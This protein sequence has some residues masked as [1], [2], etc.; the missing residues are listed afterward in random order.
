MSEHESTAFGLLHREIQ[1]WVWQQA[2]QSLRGIQEAAIPVVLEGS[3]DVLLSAATS[4]GKTE[5]AFLPLLS[6]VLNHDRPG[7]RILYLSPLKALINDQFRRL[8]T[9]CEN[10]QITV[11]RWHGDVAENRKRQALLNPSG[12]L[13]MTP[14]SLE[15]L[16]M[17][18]GGNLAAAFGNLEGVVVDEAHAYIGSERG[19]QVQ[20][21]LCRLENVAGRRIPRV[22]LSA[23]IGDLRLAAEFLRP[24]GGAEVRIV[25]VDGGADLLLQLRGYCAGPAA[26]GTE[27]E[28]T[29]SDGELS[30]S[31]DLF[32][33][34][35][36]GKN[37]VFA[38]SRKRVE[39]HAD[40]L[41]QMAAGDPGAPRF[42]VH[43]GS[44]SRQLREEAETSL[45]EG[46]HP[47]TV[48]ATTTL[49][50]G[51]DIGDIESIA[52]V[53]CPPSV[54]S[55]RQRV[56]RS[57]RRTGVATLRSFI[58]EDKIAPDSALLDK[59]RTELFQTTAMLDLM[60][61]RWTEPPEA[62]AYHL[63]TLVQQTLALIA[64]HGGA[65]ADSLFDQLCRRGPFQRTK[66]RDYVE[67][68][69][70]L[71]Q[72]SVIAQA[73][74]GLLL[75]GTQG[76]KFLAHYSFYAAFASSEEM[77]VETNGTQIGTISV[78]QVL[79]PDS[80]L[81][82]GGRRWQ[83]DSIDG[84][85]KVVFVRP[86]QGGRVPKFDP[87]GLPL[88]HANVRARMKRL[89]TEESPP[90]Y[91]D[92]TAQRLFAEGQT[93][94]RELGLEQRNVVERGQ[95][96]LLFHWHGD[97]V[98]NTIALLLRLNGVKAQTLGMAIEA[99]A[100]SETVLAAL[101]AHVDAPELTPAELLADERFI[102]REKWDPLV[103]RSL[104]ERDYALRMTDQA[105]ARALIGAILS[106]RAVRP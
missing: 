90:E 86:A 40:R 75:P 101:Q 30:A 4:S 19:A 21:L 95:S 47:V 74:D 10:L 100:A 78:S 35:R 91:L 77:R 26:G 48:V 99:S 69:R 89:Y 61:E 106:E 56:G 59:L 27:E 53:G 29:V 64:Q 94:F 11:H 98:A 28:E 81:I 79:G 32:R 71:G 23:T 80:L 7:F 63:S 34:L 57:G 58:I 8:D 15:A 49:E 45:R 72:S 83:V 105:A 102:D 51:I 87:N 5:A 20:S 67:L 97:R 3:A 55:L 60:L 12:V 31:R 73:G 70:H 13:L 52:Q 96:T 46:E 17:R 2:W 103:P 82:L 92:R 22:G 37:L 85:R 9:L 54:A 14:E 88:V 66:E 39:I 24:G 65:R 6:R 84:E 93:A 62:D 68:L 33:I 76:E 38:N 16:L 44:L 50:L 41:A 1:R 104:L 42:L 18:H 25:H 43:H 36:S